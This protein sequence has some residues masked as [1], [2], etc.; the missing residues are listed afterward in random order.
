MS[1]K[2]LIIGDGFIGKN[3]FCYFKNHYDTTITNR[4][5]LDVES[6]KSIENYFK[7][8]TFDIII[9]AVG[10]KDVKGC[11]SNEQKAY[12]TNSY[13]IK[14]LCKYTTFNKFV[15]ISTDYV[16]DG[17]KGNY[18]EEDLP[19][20]K[21][22]YGKSK[23]LGEKFVLELGDKGIVARTS[24]VFGKGCTWIKWLNNQLILNNKVECFEDV[25]NNP[26]Y[27]LDLS[28][29]IHEVLKNKY[30]GIINLCGKENLN[31]YDLFKNYSIINNFEI[32]NLIKSRNDGTFPSNLTL[33]NNKFNKM[34]NYKCLSLIDSFKHLKE[35]CNED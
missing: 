12:R 23:L 15:Y 31:R 10:F 17:I 14:T 27:V 32:N 24:G 3:L 9:Y 30:Y 35:S 13:S 22:T 20:P 5:I 33:N 34:F 4:N 29:M 6:E 19:N 2:L 7:N 26:T 28:I 21:T 18:L 25:F 16:F 1:E 11:E 8:K